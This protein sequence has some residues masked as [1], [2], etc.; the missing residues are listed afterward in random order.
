MA[1]ESPD[2]KT[3]YFEEQSRRQEEQRRWQEE[4]RRWQEEQRRREEAERAQEQAEFS[5]RKSTLPEYLDACHNY[6]H[7]GLT[8]QTDAT[9]S[10]RGDPANA[11]NKLRAEKLLE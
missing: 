1:E 6:L 4:Q 5:T 9:R 3:L 11:N 8:V 2:Y 7:S 10:T